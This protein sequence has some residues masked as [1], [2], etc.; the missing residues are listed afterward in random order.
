MNL[1]FRIIDVNEEEGSVVVRYYTDTQTEDELASLFD[2]DG[3]IIRTE[4]GY[5]VRCRTD[6]N[7]NIFDLQNIDNLNLDSI[8]ETLIR[9]TPLEW[10][11]L[12]EKIKDPNF[13]TK[14]NNLKSEIGKTYE[15][16]TEDVMKSRNVAMDQVSDSDLQ[17]LKLDTLKNLISSPVVVDLLLEEINRV[18]N[19]SNT[20]V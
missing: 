9:P 5:P 11:E 17:I 10:F 16:T 19:T 8:K 15:Y 6:M 13:E 1:K 18:A 14:F 2:E 20:S 3:D 4:E 12:Q 7:V